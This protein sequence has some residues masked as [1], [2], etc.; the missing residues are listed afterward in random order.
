MA[1]I[2]AVHFQGFSIE[3]GGSP[4]RL[5]SPRELVGNPGEITDLRFVGSAADPSHLAVATNSSVVQLYGLASKCSEAS[6]HGHTDMV[7]ALDYIQT[8]Q[9]DNILASGSKDGTFKLW[10]IKVDLY[11]LSGNL[12]GLSD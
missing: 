12:A 2:K 3:E 4:A 10:R 1:C 11:R 6:L 7:L 8:P 5:T 9:G